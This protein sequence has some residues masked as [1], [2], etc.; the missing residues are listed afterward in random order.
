MVYNFEG[1]VFIYLYDILQGVYRGEDIKFRLRDV[2]SEYMVRS[3][4]GNCRIVAKI[5]LV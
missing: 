1:R 3:K 2:F 5:L 4:S